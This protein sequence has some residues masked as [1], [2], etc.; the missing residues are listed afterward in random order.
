MAMTMRIRTCF[1]TADTFIAGFCR[2]FTE[3]TCFVPTRARREP[4]EDTTFS[5]RL[6]DGTPMLRGSCRV[7]SAWTE[8]TSPYQ[9]AGLELELLRL[10]PP[11]VELLQRILA[12]RAALAASDATVPV[13]TRPTVQMPP[14]FPDDA[15][16]EIEEDD[17]DSGALALADRT[18]PTRAP[19]ATTLGV[20]PVA[21]PAAVPALVPSEP[22]A[23]LS[24]PTPVRRTW[25]QVVVRHWH[26][27][28]AR[29][30]RALRAGRRPTRE[31]LARVALPALERMPTSRTP[32][33]AH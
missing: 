28:L 17:D 12:A 23:K 14:L 24:A 32:R 16:D 13:D 6:A 3:T 15:V 25:W 30:R 27:L 5:L 10:T 18:V 7:L 26:H 11:S 2:L 9:C 4:G 8:D 31:R 19:I 29:L 1:D 22:V 21:V 20:G 33:S